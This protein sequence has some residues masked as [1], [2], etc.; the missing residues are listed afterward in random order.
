MINPATGQKFKFEVV[1]YPVLIQPGFAVTGHSAQGNTLPSVVTDITVGGP[2]AY[3]AV[4][5]AKTCNGLVI[6]KEVQSL[7][8][9]NRPL[10]QHLVQEMGHLRTLEHNTLVLHGFSSEAMLPVKDPEG[11]LNK[12]NAHVNFTGDHATK[13]RKSAEKSTTQSKHRKLNMTPP[14]EREQM[15]GCHWDANNWSCA[16]DS[17]I[18]PLLHVVHEQSLQ[19]QSSFR[20]LGILPD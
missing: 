20:E 3:V 2:G 4:S 1:Q 10:D 11:E 19:W 13:K 15:L 9:L 7:N 17:V 6:I 5:R 14:V 12:H 16:Y 8:Q 18:V